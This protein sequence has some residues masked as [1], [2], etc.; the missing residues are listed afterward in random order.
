MPPVDKLMPM[1]AS[2]EISL[3]LCELWMYLFGLFTFAKIADNNKYVLTT[4]FVKLFHF[5]KRKNYVGHACWHYKVWMH[6]WM[7]STALCSA[8]KT[9]YRSNLLS[10]QDRFRLLVLHYGVDK[11]VLLCSGISQSLRRIKGCFILKYSF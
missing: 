2:Y 1:C 6:I 8:A 7:Q 11:R 5:H 3:C 10:A 9:M 4:T